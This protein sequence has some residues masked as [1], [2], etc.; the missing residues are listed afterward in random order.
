[1][2]DNIL[3]F[4]NLLKQVLNGSFHTVLPMC[5][6]KIKVAIKPDTTN[7]NKTP[8]GGYKDSKPNLNPSRKNRKSEDGN[9]NL[10]LNSAQDEDFMVKTGETWKDT[11]SKQLP[12]DRP[13]WDETAKV[14]NCARWMIKGNYYDNCT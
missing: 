7:V 2:N 3:D 4:K 6:K 9:S 10:V 8:S 1:M 14:K 11:F 13:F 5:F 12:L